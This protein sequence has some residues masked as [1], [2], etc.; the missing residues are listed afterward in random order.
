MLLLPGAVLHSLYKRDADAKA[1]VLL[2]LQDHGRL[3]A[4]SIV[5]TFDGASGSS[6]AEELRRVQRAAT[7]LAD[8]G[9]LG[10]AD[11]RRVKILF[12]P[13]GARD[14]ST[15][16]FVA[17]MPPAST[18]YLAA[19]RN[20]LLSSGVLDLV[21]ERCSGSSP[22][23]ARYTN[24]VGTAEILTAVE[25]AAT[26]AGCW[27]I[28]SARAENDP[29]A[30]FL[31]RSFWQSTEFLGSLGAY[32]AFVLFLI[33]VTLGFRRRLQLNL[34]KCQRLTASLRRFADANHVALRENSHAFKTPIAAIAQALEPMK[35]APQ[36]VE[37]QRRSVEIIERSVARLDAM[38]CASRKVDATAPALSEIEAK[39]DIGAFLRT[40]LDDEAEV[41][42]ARGIEPRLH[43]IAQ[44]GVLADEGHLETIIGNLLQNARAAST[45]GGRID[46]TLE[47]VA[48][49][50]GRMAALTIEDRGPGVK[51][52]LIDHIFERFSVYRA[53]PGEEENRLEGEGRYGVGLP[54][55][56]RVVELLGGSVRAENRDGGGL[57][58]IVLLPLA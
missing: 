42:Q 13:S 47:P 19:E 21:R 43:E 11:G 37:R 45:R 53:G 5:A 16:F 10:A 26:P 38:I 12:Q 17:A 51:A 3:I 7:G 49:L 32:A 31:G 56:R 27:W 28:V 34:D 54:I 6:F 33:T 52:E 25:A 41:Y 8:Q 20:A 15:L 58:V 23:S 55:V 46:I 14:A 50:H 18:E 29:A 36:D 22:L 2:Q 39:I 40:M 24:P 57:R 44:L 1:A 30:K 9:L 48:V 4:R 35:R